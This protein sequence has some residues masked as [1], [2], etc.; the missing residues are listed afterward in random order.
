MK[1]KKGRLFVV[2]GG[3][4]ADDN[5]IWYAPTPIASYMNELASYFDECTWLIR[6]D[7]SGVG[8]FEGTIDTNRIRIIADGDSRFDRLYRWLY[9]LAM[10]R[11]FSHALF[12]MPASVPLLLAMPFA[13]RVL[14]SM[15]IYLGVDHRYWS[16][17]TRS[18]R[19]PGSPLLFK[20]AHEYPMRIADAVIVRGQFLSSLASDF[21]ER[22]V[23]TYPLGSMDLD[24]RRTERMS[25]GAGPGR[26]LFVGRVVWFKGL[27]DLLEATRMLV[28]AGQM[29]HLDIVGD[30]ADREAIEKWVHEVQ[31]HHYVS[32]HG[33]VDNKERLSQLFSDADVLVVPSSDS[34]GVPRVIDEALAGNLPVIATNVGGVAAEFLEDEL[35]L[36]EARDPLLLSRAISAMLFDHSTRAR[37]LEGAKRRQEKWA[38]YT[39]AAQQHAEILHTVARKREKS[40]N[41]HTDAFS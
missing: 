16:T 6:K 2:G 39:G 4:V 31:F 12:Y 18:A 41:E 30:G 19:V 35:M 17:L 37:Y 23:E 38:G 14:Q 24:I 34:E 10:I 11:H 36:V 7:L 5:G 32:F 27:R 26:I 22:V 29:V 33:Y 25:D 8:V 40:W 21:N 20:L 28:E 1:N 13:R 3:S 9:F 15:V